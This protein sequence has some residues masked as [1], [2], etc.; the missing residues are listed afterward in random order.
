MVVPAAPAAPYPLPYAPST[1]RM[2]AVH[3][4]A[5]AILRVLA[6]ATA[7]MTPT[8]IAAQIDAAEAT[9]QGSTAVRVCM[10]R[11]DRAGHVVRL[12][13]GQYALPAQVADFTAVRALPPLERAQAALGQAPWTRR[14]LEDALGIGKTGAG[15]L[16]QSWRAA[17]VIV[18]HATLPPTY[19]FV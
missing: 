3:P 14:Q 11:L 13:H 4:R 6:A 19:R 2:R 9:H 5:Q 8:Q 17:G 16:L 12:G 7:P 1:A 18:M 10:R 15:D